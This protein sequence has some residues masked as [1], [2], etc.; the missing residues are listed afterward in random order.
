MQE[1]TNN[2]GQPDQDLVRATALLRRSDRRGDALKRLR[3]LYPRASDQP[4]ELLA[5]HLYVDA[6][7]AL[8][9]VLSQWEQLL[10]GE[11]DSLD[12]GAIYHLLYHLYNGLILQ[13]LLGVEGGDLLELA[14][15]AL[16]AAE[17][18]PDLDGLR[19]S[20]TLM[21]AMLGG[22]ASPPSEP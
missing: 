1:K 5:F 11:R 19:R 8:I 17:G 2:S 7:D 18:D 10:T 12:S 21:A 4:L 15:E 6:P 3:E 22:S 14:R 20:V 13:R 9:A 16:S